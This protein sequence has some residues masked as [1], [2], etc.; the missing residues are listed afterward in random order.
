[1]SPTTWIIPV[2]FRQA[3]AGSF[4]CPLVRIFHAAPNGT[5]TFNTKGGGMT[6]IFQNVNPNGNWSFYMENLFE[7]GTAPQMAGGWC[8]DFNFE[9][10]RPSTQKNQYSAN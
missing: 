4:P 2:L 6:G 7:P 5:S 10:S 3:R 8:L 1:M 9:S